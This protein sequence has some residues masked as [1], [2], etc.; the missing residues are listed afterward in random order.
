VTS[1]FPIQPSL[2]I[3]EQGVLETKRSMPIVEPDAKEEVPSDIT[4]SLKPMPSP[5]NRRPR[6]DSVT[7][8]SGGGADS[9]FRLLP[10]EARP[11]IRRMLFV[12]P[13]ARCTL[14]DLL[15]V[16]GKTSGLLCGCQRA[17]ANGNA[18]SSTSSFSMG[19]C[20]DHDDCDEEDDGDEWL[21]SISPCSTPGVVPTHVHIKVAVDEKQGKRKIF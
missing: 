4:V 5:L 6:S 7:T 16:R 8:F 17:G 18:E 19:H 20:V 1:A 3:G 12:E 13:T 9:I 11:V 2:N 21:K 15:K 14:T 10:R